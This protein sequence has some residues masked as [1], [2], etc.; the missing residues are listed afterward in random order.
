[1]RHSLFGSDDIEDDDEEYE[2]SSPKTA[3]APLNGRVDDSA[4]YLHSEDRIT[5]V[6]T[7]LKCGKREPWR[8]PE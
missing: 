6:D 4:S 3:R 2:Y 1:M 8:V 5:D 7:T